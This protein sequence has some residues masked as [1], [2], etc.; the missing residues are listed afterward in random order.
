VI[1]NQAHLL[2]RPDTAASTLVFTLLV[3]FTTWG[4]SSSGTGESACTASDSQALKICSTGVVTKGVDVSKYQANVNWPAVKTSGRAFGFARVSDG[5]SY[6]DSTFATNWSGMKSAGLV[7]GAY[8]YFRPGQDPVAQ[9]DLLISKLG[10]KIAAADL[11]AVLDLETTDGLP[12]STVVAHAKT[13]LARVEA[14]TGKRPIVYTAAFMSGTIG[15]SFSAYPLW[16]ANYGTTCPTMPTGWSDW[17]FWQSSSSGAVPGIAGNVDVNDFRGALADLKAFAGAPS[18]DAGTGD[19]SDA[20]VT[21]DDGTLEV[22]P[23]PTYDASGRDDGSVMGDGLRV[24]ATL[25]SCTP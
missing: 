5:L 19:G 14:G 15:T 8:Q 9:A 3:A 4:C 24:G 23:A 11:P 7:R 13:W 16:V 21:D 20:G 25:G 12:S 10:G 22:P 18:G 6:P 17:K 1:S 2:A